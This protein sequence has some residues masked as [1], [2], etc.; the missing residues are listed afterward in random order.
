MGMRI[1]SSLAKVPSLDY[2]SNSKDI[3]RQRRKKAQRLMIESTPE[4]LI[5]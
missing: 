1:G 2:C 3:K 4:M 5:T